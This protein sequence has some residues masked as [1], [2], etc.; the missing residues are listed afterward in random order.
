[1]GEKLYVY[2][3]S[4]LPP[5]RLEIVC[6]MISNTE[7]NIVH[8]QKLRFFSFVPGSFGKITLHAWKLS[9]YSS[10]VDGHVDTKIL[11]LATKWMRKYLTSIANLVILIFRAVG[12]NFRLMW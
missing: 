6:L 7:M 5:P 1:M 4:P 12:K 2:S 8:E 10:T 11:K 3:Y 9:P